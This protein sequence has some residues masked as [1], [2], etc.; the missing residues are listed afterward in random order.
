M[1]YGVGHRA[2]WDSTPSLRTSYATSVALKSQKK[3]KDLPLGI[4][5]KRVWISK[6]D[7]LAHSRC[8]NVILVTKQEVGTVL[9]L[10]FGEAISLSGDSLLSTL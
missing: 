9:T 5:D 1:S 4:T 6:A 3:K 10:P 7:N 2:G 8:F